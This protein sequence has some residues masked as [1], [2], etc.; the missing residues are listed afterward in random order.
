M[1]DND[2]PAD[3]PLARAA[4][5]CFG[6]AAYGAGLVWTIGGAYLYSPLAWVV[7]H[8]AMLVSAIFVG[9]CAVFSGE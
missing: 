6:G 5:R 9:L 1:S 3:G 4:K 7:I 8:L 2:S